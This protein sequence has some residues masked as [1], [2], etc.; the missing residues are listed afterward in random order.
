MLALLIYH[1]IFTS[2]EAVANTTGG[3]YLLEKL[4]RNRGANFKII[5][6]KC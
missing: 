3:D 1:L 2:A 5:C 6:R 4:L